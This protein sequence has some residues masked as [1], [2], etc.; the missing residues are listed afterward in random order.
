MGASHLPQVH[1]LNRRPSGFAWAMEFQHAS[2]VCPES[3]RPDA[4]VIVIDMMTGSLFPASSKKF[5]MAK[6]AALRLRVSKVVSGIKSSQRLRPLRAFDLLVVRLYQFVKCNIPKRRVVHIRRKGCG[7]I[8]WTN[9]TC[10]KS[11]AVWDLFPLRN[12]LLLGRALQMQCS[13]LPQF[14][15]G[16]S[17]PSR[18]WYR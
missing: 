1:S 4:S 14:L 3:V 18:C 7:A 2:V 15:R 17:Q 12:L 13:H 6:I 8:C 11:R 9:C 10:H 16:C 5:S